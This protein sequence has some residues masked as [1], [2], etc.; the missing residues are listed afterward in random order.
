M[1]DYTATVQVRVQADDPVAAGQYVMEA[2][3][4]G[5]DEIYGQTGRRLNTIA[6]TAVT[7][8]TIPVREPS[9]V[10]KPKSANWLWASYAGILIIA[11]LGIISFLLAI[12]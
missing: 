4:R 2:L 1:T 10:D 8:N 5:D 9:Y 12:T 7:Y 3:K 6:L 11:I